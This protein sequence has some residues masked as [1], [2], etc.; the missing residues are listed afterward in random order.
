MEWWFI[1]YINCSLK[2]FKLWDFVKHLLRLE[3]LPKRVSSI[4]LTLASFAVP[5]VGK[6]TP[7]RRFTPGQPLEVLST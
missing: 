2:Q 5:P 7:R 6:T 1:L 3:E 4:K